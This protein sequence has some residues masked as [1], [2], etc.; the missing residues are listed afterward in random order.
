MKYKIKVWVP[1]EPSSK[2][3]VIYTDITEALS[4]QL[5]LETMQPE[6]V[7]EIVPV[8]EGKNATV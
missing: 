1:V 3:D 6:N 2:D 5:E 7:Y 4:T 8:I